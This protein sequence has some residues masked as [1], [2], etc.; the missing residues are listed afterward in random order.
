MHS[1]SDVKINPQ[2]KV[3]LR[4]EEYLST[5]FFQKRKSNKKF[6]IAIVTRYLC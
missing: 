4:N 5:V 3:K 6:N 1:Y 2:K